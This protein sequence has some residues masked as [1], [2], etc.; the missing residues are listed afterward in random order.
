MIFVHD[1]VMYTFQVFIVPFADGGV[2]IFA[3]NAAVFFFPRIHP[4]L[5]EYTA[6]KILV[7]FVFA[8]FCVIPEQ[9]T[10]FHVIVGQIG[11]QIIFLAPLS[12][13]AGNI[14]TPCHSPVNDALL[15][16]FQ[17]FFPKFFFQILCQDG[18]K[19]ANRTNMETGSSIFCGF[20]F[21]TPLFYVPGSAADTA[22]PS[23]RTIV[24]ICFL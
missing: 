24:F 8:I 2:D 23:T 17:A 1:M 20:K 12:S 16:D 21:Y 18:K 19:R 11:I 6:V 3:V 7:D 5:G 22:G 9:F 4:G 10:A 15:Q 13:P 14:L